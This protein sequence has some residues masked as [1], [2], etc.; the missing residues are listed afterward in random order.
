MAPL[1]ALGALLSLGMLHRCP[2]R[3]AD[4]AGLLSVNALVSMV[5]SAGLTSVPL[6][7]WVLSLFSILLNSS[8]EAA[9]QGETLTRCIWSWL[10][11]SRVCAGGVTSRCHPTS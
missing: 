7:A 3:C 11:S 8:W 5:F 4:T 2:G 9:W 10:H 6:E 1:S